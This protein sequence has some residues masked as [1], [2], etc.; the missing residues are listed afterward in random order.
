MKRGY[1]TSILA[2]M[3]EHIENAGAEDHDLNQTINR[4]HLP[5]G[6]SVNDE[7]L[8]E[9]KDELLQLSVQ[10]EEQRSSDPLPSLDTTEGDGE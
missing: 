9:Y 1:S 5:P 7:F 2:A 3:L 6:E 4:L 10:L 8:E